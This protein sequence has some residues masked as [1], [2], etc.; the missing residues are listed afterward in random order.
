MIV[1]E[2]LISREV[3][4]QKNGAS[5]IFTDLFIE[6][7]EWETAIKRKKAEAESYESRFQYYVSTGVLDEHTSQFCSLRK[8]FN[9]ISGTFDELTLAIKEYQKELMA[10]LYQE[11]TN[12]DKE[13]LLQTHQDLSKYCKNYALSLGPQLIEINEKLDKVCFSHYEEGTFYW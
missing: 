4:P 8:I 10:V 11:N 5:Q 2:L 1:T 9:T 6:T 3:K 7:M 13:V 12:P